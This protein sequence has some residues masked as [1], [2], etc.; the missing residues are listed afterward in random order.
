MT[1][2]LGVLVGRFQIHTLTDGHK[3]LFAQV[4]G[5][6]SRVLALV[7]VPPVLGTRRDPLDYLVR[8]RMLQDYWTDAYREGPE[9]TVLPSIDCPSNEEWARRIDQMIDAVAPGQAATIFCGPDGC[10]PL[11][12]TAGGRHPIEVIESIPGHTHATMARA[13]LQRRHTEDFRAGV[14]YFSERRWL[15]PLPIVDVAV[16][17]GEE[18]LLG[19]KADEHV[20][21]RL[22]GGFVDLADRTLELAAKREVMEET[23][24]EV[25]NLRYAGSALIDDW[26]YR[27]TPEQMLSTVF[28]ADYV[29]GNPQPKDDIARVAWHSIPE[30]P[31]LLHPNHH[32][33]WSHVQRHLLTAVTPA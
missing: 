10:G 1:R 32:D 28:V 23:G 21:W 29:F 19:Q 22:I 31:R 2:P 12:R 7:G 6:C 25:G 13:A 20:R 17:K 30:V 18:V 5:R 3:Y 26:R 9:L 8:A 16:I 33:L 14:I 15:N 11:Y 27:S 24:L 4:A